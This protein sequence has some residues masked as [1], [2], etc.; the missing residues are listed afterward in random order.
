MN[1]FW[2]NNKIIIKS[3]LKKDK[4]CHKLGYCPYGQLVEEFPLRNKSDKK[5]SCKVFGHD[6][7]MFYHAEDMSDFGVRREIIDKEKK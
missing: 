5:I 7:P 4:P 1:G 3:N 6:C 2:L